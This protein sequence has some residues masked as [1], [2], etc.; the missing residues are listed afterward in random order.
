MRRFHPA[1]R[2]ALLALAL[3]ACAK[4]VPVDKREY[5]G[6]WVGESVTL[7]IT[8]DGHLDYRRRRPSG[9]VSL[10]GPLR[11]FEADGFRFGIGP[12]STFFRVDRRPHQQDGHW[13][14][15]VDG[16]PLVRVP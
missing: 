15:T 8:A 12:L 14:M 1:A 5:V 13:V 7:T 2:G 4:P 16:T 3:A 6:A 11:S 10:D 9:S